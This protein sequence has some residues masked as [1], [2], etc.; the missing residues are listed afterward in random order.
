M[1]TMNGLILELLLP[2]LMNFTFNQTC[3]CVVI[4]VLRR[5]NL[6]LSSYRIMGDNQSEHQP[7]DR[8][9]AL[10]YSGGTY[11]QKEL[12]YGAVLTHR[13]TGQL[14]AG[15]TSIGPHVNICMLYTA[16]L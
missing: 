6:S 1:Q 7:V 15:P 5:L 4:K 10:G 2:C 9:F 12:M 3:R 13:H 8:V 11:T 16:C 14:P